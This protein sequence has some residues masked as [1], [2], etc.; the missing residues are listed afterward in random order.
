M[1]LWPLISPDTG[2]HYTR[3]WQAWT[4]DSIER[5]QR[6]RGRRVEGGGGW[7]VWWGS[8]APVW[9]CQLHW[10]SKSASP[11]A[12]ANIS[13]L[14][15]D[16]SLEI[17]GLFPSHIQ[18]AEDGGDEL[19]LATTPCRPLCKSESEHN[20]TVPSRLSVNTEQFRLE[21]QIKQQTRVHSN[22]NGAE[23]AQEAQM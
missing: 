9:T 23:E 2:N 16:C 12:A 14:L 21:R 15:N 10:P 3:L 13:P 18:K 1:Q 6:G 11:E 20:V 17:D 5:G 4:T 19:S 8:A 7:R 22:A